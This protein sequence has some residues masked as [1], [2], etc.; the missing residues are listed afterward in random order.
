MFYNK[1]LLLVS[2]F[3]IF[4]ENLKDRNDMGHTEIAMP[5]FVQVLSPHWIRVYRASL[6]GS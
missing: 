4:F 1:I 6:A 2:S 3:L 5:L